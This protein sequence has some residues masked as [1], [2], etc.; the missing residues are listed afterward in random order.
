MKIH[1]YQAKGLFREFGIPVQTGAAVASPHEA[2]AAAAE[3]GLP[4]VLKA[5]VHVGGRGKAGGVKLVD[6]AEAVAP[7]AQRILGLTIKGLPVRK[8]LVSPAVDVASEVYLSLLIDRGASKLVFIGC[9]EGGVEIEETAKTSPEKILRLEVPSA[10]IG[11]LEPADCLDFAGQLFRGP[12][13]ARAAAVLMSK[14]GRLFKERDC[15]LIEINPLVVTGQGDLLALDA[16]IL[17]DDNGLIRHPQNEALRD[18][19]SES[20]DEL[21]AKRAGLT[22]IRLDGN[23]GCMVNGA[24]LAMATMD[25]IKHFGGEPANFLDVGGSSNPNKVVTAFKAILKDPKVRLI[26]IN[27]FG[28]ITR[29]DDIARGIL[30]AR[31][32]IAVPVPIVVRLVGTNQKEGRALLKDTEMTVASTLEEGARLAVQ[33]IGSKP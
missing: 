7:A 5:Q 14:M 18:V 24:G 19:D 25:I 8:I 20:A 17:L 31:E 15:E 23:I 28:G 33:M 6:K 12:A 21:E 4:V 26:L 10:R 30:A 16:K 9:A 22:F 13:H 2:A 29:C 3:M 11:A 1:E 27:I 32:Q